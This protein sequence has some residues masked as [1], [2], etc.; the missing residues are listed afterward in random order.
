LPRTTHW[1]PEIT[2]HHWWLIALLL[3]A[4]IF[5]IGVRATAMI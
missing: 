2:H 3:L 4:A 1:A 5:V